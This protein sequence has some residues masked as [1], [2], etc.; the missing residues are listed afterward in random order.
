M[1]VQ[2]SVRLASTQAEAL[3]D[4]LAQTAELAEAVSLSTSLMERA[5]QTAAIVAPAVGNGALPVG[6]ECAFCE[7]HQGV[8]DGLSWEDYDS[9]YGGFDGFVERSRVGPPDGESIEG[10][11]ARTGSALR[12]LADSRERGMAVVI[13]HGGTVG[14]ALEVLLGVRMGS[15]T[16]SIENTSITEMAWDE[17][18]G[19]WMLV[20]LNDAAHLWR[21]RSII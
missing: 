5:A 7:Q 15:I 14:A 4:R 3:R 21:A 17:R 16:R 18:I 10:L 19:R 11:V 12:Q 8:G 6:A 20:R 2:A 9:R 1:G 13:G